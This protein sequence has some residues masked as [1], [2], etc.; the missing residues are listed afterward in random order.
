MLAPAR[1]GRD[2]FIDATRARP[3]ARSFDC[4]SD[5]PREAS[6]PPARG[7]DSVPLGSGGR[8]PAA[9]HRASV[10]AARR[11]VSAGDSSGSRPVRPLG[12]G[13]GRGGSGA[14]R[15]ASGGGFAGADSTSGAS[16]GS[17]RKPPRHSARAATS[18]RT[19]SPPARASRRHSR[20]G[21]TWFAARPRISGPAARRRSIP[22]PPISS[23]PSQVPRA[24]AP[25]TIAASS[26][27]E[28]S[29]PS[30]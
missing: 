11:A 8:R 25:V 5:H 4:L 3:F 18:R 14:R 22:G 15:D 12:S 13:A 10:R 20:P 6:A 7:G 27:A 17:A 21:S 30:A 2:D 26:G 19:A 29:P 9:R 23:V 24:R 16:R 28:G 1:W